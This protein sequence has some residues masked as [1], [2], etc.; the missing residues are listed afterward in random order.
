MKVNKLFA[1]LFWIISCGLIT[2]AIFAYPKYIQERERFVNKSLNDKEQLATR[3]DID[4][5]KEIK[6]AK[7]DDTCDLTT[8]VS[9]NTRL[10]A[11]MDWTFG[12]KAQRGWRLYAPLICQTVNTKNSEVTSKDFAL[13]LYRWQK[14]KGLV[15][16][17]ILDTDTWYQMIAM[18]QSQRIKDREYPSPDQLTTAPI[19]D[20]YDPTRAEELRKVELETYAAYKRM[21]A[22]AI[23]D[24]SL[25]LQSI[26]K[27]ELAPEEKYLK[28]I[29]A[30]RSREY[31]EQLRKQSPHSG[32]A[33]LAVNSPHFTG[34]ALDIYVGGDPVET[35]EYNRNIQTQTPVYKWLVK[36][37]HKFGFYPYY[38]EPWHWEYSP[39]NVATSKIE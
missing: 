14:A 5:E 33:G 22:A 28:I 31:Q 36:N 8:A 11:N 20:F 15:P 35:N 1:S 34:R 24:P 25:R 32:R 16:N 23:A 3:S 19:S 2:T 12:G 26:N 17:G 27:T 10:M 13:A 4:L 21:V 38:Y 29:S 6:T 7:V 9:E 30:F 37:A 18:W 39:I